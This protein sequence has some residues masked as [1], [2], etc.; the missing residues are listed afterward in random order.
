M[1]SFTQQV[2]LSYQPMPFLTDNGSFA[3]TSNRKLDLNLY[4]IKHPQKTCFIQVTNPNMLA[5]GIEIGDMLV[6]EKSEHLSIGDLV[7]MEQDHKFCIYEFVAYSG[8]E[9]IFLPLDAKMNSIKCD[10]WATLPI[11]G[12]ITNT[13]RQIKSNK[14]TRFTA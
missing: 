14:K 10:K 9:F 7:V 8:K 6:V 5:W 3:S 13:I 2:Q 4:C 11:I 12:I 1:N